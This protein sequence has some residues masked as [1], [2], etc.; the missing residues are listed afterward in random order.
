MILP[1]HFD[2]EVFSYT[3][4]SKADRCYKRL[5]LFSFSKRL[6]NCTE[7]QILYLYVNLYE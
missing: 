7:I 6:T 5:Y 4:N 1:H 2:Y 3:T